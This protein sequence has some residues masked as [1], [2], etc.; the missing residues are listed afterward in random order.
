MTTNLIDDLRNRLAAAQTNTESALDYAV[1]L[2]GEAAG[3]IK[4]LE[5]FQQEV[6]LLIAEIFTETGIT[7]ARTSSGQVYISKPSVRVS[8]DSKG[9]DTLAAKDDELAGLLA[10]FRKVTQVAGS[11]VVRTGGKS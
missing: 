3:S 10:P 5:E 4:A 6:K 7:E 9:L 11:L 8:W 2:Y 1:G